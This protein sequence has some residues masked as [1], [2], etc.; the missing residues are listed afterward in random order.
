MVEGLQAVV[1][2][3]ILELLSELVTLIVLE[4]LELAV[5][6]KSSTANMVMNCIIYPQGGNL[7]IVVLLRWSL[8]PTW[9]F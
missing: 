8:L 4:V 2:L 9:S 7:S 3:L 6:R 5:V 1:V